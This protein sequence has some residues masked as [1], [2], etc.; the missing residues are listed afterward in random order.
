[1]VGLAIFALLGTACYQLLNSLTLS[2]ASLRA[3]SDY[4][5][6]VAKALLVID[7]DLRHLIPRSV[8]TQGAEQRQAALSSDGSGRVEFSRGG[9][10][11]RRS[12]YLD[13][14]RRISYSIELEQDEQVLYRDV[15][16]A[17][18]RVDGTPAYRQELLR[19]V[20]SLALRFLDDDGLWRTAWP[21]QVTDSANTG[22]EPDGQADEPVA[23]DDALVKLPRA[24]EVAIG[25]PAD[26][27]IARLISLQ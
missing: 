3:A 9:L 21:P 23:G 27:T 7:Q 16:G 19:N 13:G 12:I 18:D 26:T 2:Q 24:I 25:L 17:L 6:S 15:Y 22:D 4:R 14:A 11:L 20:R 8:R 1:M 5:G 10:P